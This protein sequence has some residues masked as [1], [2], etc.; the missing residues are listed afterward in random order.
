MTTERAPSITLP[1]SVP[2][3]TGSGR[4]VSPP[5]PHH[6]RQRPLGRAATLGDAGLPLNRRRSSIFSEGFSEIRKSLR[7]STDDLLLPRVSGDTRH[8]T[9]QEASHWHSIPLGLALLPAVGGLLFNNGS[10]IFTDITLL[11]LAAI[12]LNW[13]VRLPWSALPSRV[14]ALSNDA[15][16]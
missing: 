3:A 5:P 8:V 13:S 1:L 10:A 4:H 2:P 7:T 12:F 6:L 16:S 15:Q 9:Q 11:V 14:I